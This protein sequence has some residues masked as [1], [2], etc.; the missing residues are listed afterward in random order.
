[1]SVPLPARLT[2]LTSDWQQQLT[3]VSDFS[4]YKQRL[5]VWNGLALTGGQFLYTLHLAPLVFF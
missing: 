3:A 5:F 2:E 1:M 4:D